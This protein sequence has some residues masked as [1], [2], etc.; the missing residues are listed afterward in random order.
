LTDQRATIP[1]NLKVVYSGARKH[2]G[3]SAFIFPFSQSVRKNDIKKKFRHLSTKLLSLLT[4]EI[5]EI[6]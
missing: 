3:S 6:A 1:I 4:S 5:F 2:V